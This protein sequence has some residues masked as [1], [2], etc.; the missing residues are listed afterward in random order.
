MRSIKEGVDVNEDS[1]LFSLNPSGYDDQNKTVANAVKN[2]NCSS[3]ELSGDVVTVKPEALDAV[4]WKLGGAAIALRLV[5]LASV[6][7]LCISQVF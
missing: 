7:N 5:E 6:S 2:P 3:A 4:L 1:F